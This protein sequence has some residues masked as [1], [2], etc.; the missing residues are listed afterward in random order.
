MVIKKQFVSLSNIKRTQTEYARKKCLGDWPLQFALM[1]HSFLEIELAEMVNEKSNRIIAS[2]ITNGRSIECFSKKMTMHWICYHIH[3]IIY[4]LH[5]LS[6]D[7]PPF[8]GISRVSHTHTHKPTHTHTNKHTQNKTQP[9]GLGASNNPCE[10]RQQHIHK[11]CT[12][13]HTHTH[14]HSLTHND[15]R[16]KWLFYTH[17]HTHTHTQIKV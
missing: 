9:Q 7:L 5:I 1:S 4:N 2:S 16:H 15:G 11:N 12:H 6:R 17:T 8:V 14:T 10:L 13:L 3:T